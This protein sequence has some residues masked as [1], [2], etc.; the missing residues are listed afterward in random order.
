MA[1][2]ATMP[3]IQLIVPP[4]V[5]R[6]PPPRSWKVV[7]IGAMVRPLAMTQDRPR[8]MRSPPR[9]TMKEGTPT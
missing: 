8:Q 4:T 6:A 1:S 2:A 5:P 7:S 9:V 3:M